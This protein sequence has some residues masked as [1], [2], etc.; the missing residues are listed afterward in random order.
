MMFANVLLAFVFLSS[1]AQ[2]DP[3]QWTIKSDAPGSPLAT[4]AKFN[5]M[6][7]ATIGDGWHLYSLDQPPGGP[8]P[9]RIGVPE[10][11]AFKLGGEIDSPP[12]HTQFDP[13]FNIETQYYE[14]SVEFIVPIVVAAT[15]VKGAT[16]VKVSARYQTCN[17]ESVFHQGCHADRR[18]PARR[19]Q[20]APPK[21]C[22]VQVPDFAFVDF[23]Q[24]WK[25]RVSRQA[26]FNGFLG[27]VVRAM[28][29]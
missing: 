17:S 4:G 22:W 15:D 21:G 16:P 10:G 19:E 25:F 9:T 29:G 13:V 28:P 5:L 11:Q 2:T 20:A 6:L 1:Q 12:P 23:R 27:D 24:T 7:T 8:T 26:R 18:C 14:E 3:I